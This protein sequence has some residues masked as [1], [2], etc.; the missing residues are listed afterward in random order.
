MSTNYKVISAKAVLGV[1]LTLKLTDKQ[2]SIRKSALKLKKKGG[3]YVV[4]DPVEFKKGENITIV[5]GAISKSVLANLEDLSPQS[6]NQEQ[7][8][9][10][11][12]TPAKKGKK[13]KSN[14]TLTVKNK[15]KKSAPE[16]NDEKIINNGNIN[17]LPTANK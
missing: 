9:S 15:R 13:T 11:N 6:Q 7:K 3:I 12:K 5:D 8:I 1:G 2:A 17:D 10:I 4:L 14:S 16:N